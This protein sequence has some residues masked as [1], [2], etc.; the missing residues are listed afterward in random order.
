MCDM[1][2]LVPGFG[3]SNPVGLSNRLFHCVGVWDQWLP[4]QEQLY[5]GRRG[6]VQF[7]QHESLDGPQYS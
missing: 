7:W 2:C 1:T 6:P 3:I 5:S 4:A